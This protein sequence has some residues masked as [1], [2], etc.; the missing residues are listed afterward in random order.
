LNLFQTDAAI[1][2][3]NSGGALINKNGELI[4]INSAI[5]SQTELCWICICNTCKLGQENS[6]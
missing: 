5:A 4:G 1:N 6:R 2:P 3:G